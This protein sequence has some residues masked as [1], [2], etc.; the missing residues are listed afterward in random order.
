MGQEV[1]PRKIDE[2]AGLLSIKNK[3]FGE[4]LPKLSKTT[5][6]HAVARKGLTFDVKTI[7]KRLGGTILLTFT[8]QGQ[9][10]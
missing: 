7:R 4:A 10:H 2:R 6:K 9:G 5:L 1:C 8:T 3:Q